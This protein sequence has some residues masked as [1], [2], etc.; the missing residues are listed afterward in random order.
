[1]SFNASSKVRGSSRSIKRDP[2]KLI[3]KLFQVLFP[4]GP[5]RKVCLAPFQMFCDESSYLSCC[6][7]HEQVACTIHLKLLS[8]FGTNLIS[9]AI[10]ATRSYESIRSLCSY[11]SVTN[12]YLIGMSIIHHFLQPSLH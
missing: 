12:D 4:S 3:C 1:M 10:R 5:Y 2:P 7:Q 11:V 6:T 8:T 9:A